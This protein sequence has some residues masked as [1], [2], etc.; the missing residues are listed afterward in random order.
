MIS[1]P[2]HN[3]LLIFT[4]PG[5]AKSFD[6][7]DYWDGGDLIYAGRGKVGDQKLQG[8][9]RDLAENRRVVLAFEPNG[10][11]QVR[12]LGQAHCVDHWWTQEPDLKGELRRVLRYR[13]RF[14]SP[15]P[16]PA[17]DVSGTRVRRPARRQARRFDP[18]APPPAP[19]RPGQ[20]GSTPEERA[21]LLEQATK[22]HHELVKTLAVHLAKAGWTQIEEVPGGPDLWATKADRRVIFEAKTLRNSNAAHQVRLAIAQLLEYRFI[23]GTSSDSLCLLTDAP[24]TDQRSRLLDSLNIG[25]LSK[26]VDG[27]RAAGRVA[28]SIGLLEG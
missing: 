13:L 16:S 19:P 26:D 28:P 12:L 7:G 17:A 8:Q 23:Y 14:E 21:Q 9:N 3:T 18:A 15:P 10:A 1:R 2:K 5:G 6:Y 27:I 24:V 20:P 11:R 4:H 25:F 22:G